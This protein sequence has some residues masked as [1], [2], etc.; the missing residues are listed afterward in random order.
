MPEWIKVVLLMLLVLASMAAVFVLPGLIVLG[1]QLPWLAPHMV[2]LVGLGLVG[3]ACLLP[4]EWHD[5]HASNSSFDFTPKLGVMY[6]GGLLVI[7]WLAWMF[8]GF[9]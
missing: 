4:G 7:S 6:F 8:P 3:I 1:A 9:F 2:L 5:P